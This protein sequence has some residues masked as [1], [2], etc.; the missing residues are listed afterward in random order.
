M[1]DHGGESPLS[2]F[3]IVLVRAKLR[4]RQQLLLVGQAVRVEAVVA[5]ASGV[6]VPVERGDMKGD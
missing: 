3:Q 5:L 6:K 1:V 4:E 2:V